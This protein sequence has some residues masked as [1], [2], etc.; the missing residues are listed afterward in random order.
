MSPC[1]AVVESGD[2]LDGSPFRFRG[3]GP[4]AEAREDGSFRTWYVTEGLSKSIVKPAT[5]SVYV[6]VGK[7][8]WEP[9]VVPTTEARATVLSDSEME[10]DLGFVAIP[11]GMRPY[12]QDA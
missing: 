5:V 10:L 9:I 3:A 7:G 11:M 2:R 12:V 8:D 6:R 4:I 1:E